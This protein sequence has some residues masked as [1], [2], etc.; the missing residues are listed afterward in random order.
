MRIRIITSARYSDEDVQKTREYISKHRTEG[1]HVKI[2]S[3][4]LPFKVYTSSSSPDCFYISESVK[5]GKNLLAVPLC[6]RIEDYEQYLRSALSVGR[7]YDGT[8]YTTSE[9]FKLASGFKDVSREIDFYLQDVTNNSMVI[10][11]DITGH[12]LA[13]YITSVAQRIGL[14]NAKRAIRG[15]SS[16]QITDERSYINR[17]EL[18]ENKYGTL[19]Y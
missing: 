13:S 16:L 9:L 11:A 15:L 14:N 7:L 12:N 8:C 18:Y 10:Y 17:E 19:V 4:N 2:G 6:C 3:K 1:R 5:D